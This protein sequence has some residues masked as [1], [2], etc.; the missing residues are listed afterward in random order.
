MRFLCEVLLAPSVHPTKQTVKAE[1]HALQ[2]TT[3][4]PYNAIP[5]NLLGLGS[6][7]G[8]GRDQVGIHSIRLPDRY[9]VAACSTVETVALLSLAL[10][11]DVQPFAHG[12]L[13]LSYCD[14]SLV[15][16]YAFFITK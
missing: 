7:R 8:L 2:C 1:N 11:I 13:S 5:S 10:D 15:W 16:I 9:R 12:V 4:R 6:V 3:A 14:H